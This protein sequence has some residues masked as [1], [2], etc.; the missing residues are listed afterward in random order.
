MKK[1]VFTLM[2]MFLVSSILLSQQGGEGVAKS[3]EEKKAN[4]KEVKKT[5]KKEERKTEKEVKRV[6]ERRRK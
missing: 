5:E 1:T 2:I 4:P 3:K 6:P